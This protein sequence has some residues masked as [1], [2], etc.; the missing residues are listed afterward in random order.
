MGDSYQTLV[1][2]DA[3]EAEAGHLG[4]RVRGWLL[5]RG[6]VQPSPEGAEKL[7]LGPS[8][9]QALDEPWLASTR[10][11]MWTDTDALRVK[12]GRTVF[13]AVGVE[14]KCPA[15]GHRFEPDDEAWG[16]A[17]NAWY[18]GDDAVTLPCPGCGHV[19][20][21]TEWDGP[22]PWAFAHLG[23]ELWNWPHLSKRFVRE[24]A[25]QLGGHRVRLV[26]SK[27]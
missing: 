26:C 8:F 18:E 4:A 14:L 3:T 21:L 6:I 20:K 17:V 25:E 7:A 19:Q 16:A 10:S 23:F 13:F 22:H 27:L 9:A 12:E 15:C 11:A 5:A 24:V 1:D 2:L